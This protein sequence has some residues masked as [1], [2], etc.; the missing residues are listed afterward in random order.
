[1]IDERRVHGGEVYARHVAGY[2]VFRRPWA[3][4]AGVV[5]RG[6][7]RAR[8]S[9][10]SEALR[11]VGGGVV[12]ERLVRVV[13]GNAGEARVP[14]APATALLQPVRLKTHSLHALGSALEDVK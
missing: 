8:R 5:L 6:F 4:L 13:A 1:M 11:V 9:V 7:P 2:A 3:G 14:V 10:A 12:V